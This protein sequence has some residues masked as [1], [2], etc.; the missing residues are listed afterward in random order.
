MAVATWRSP[1]TS[2]SPGT[3][4]PPST[5][6]AFAARARELGATIALDTP[7]EALLVAGGKVTGVPHG[8]G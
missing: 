2:R 3:P 7:V 1:P 4:T 5:T 6:N 8:G